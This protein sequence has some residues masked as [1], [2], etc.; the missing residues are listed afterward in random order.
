MK[1]AY[2]TSIS[3]GYMFALN[4]NMNANMYYGTNADFVIIQSQMEPEY[5]KAIENAFPFKIK[6]INRDDYS[7]C[8]HNCKYAVASTLKDD[9]DAICLIDS[10]LFICCDTTPYFY[11]ASQENVLI[12]AGHVW[13]GGDANALPFD[14]PESLIDRGQAQL[15]DFPIFINP[16]FGYKLF[17]KWFDHTLEGRGDSEANHPLV[18]FN[19]AIV[20]TLKKEELVVLPGDQWV[21]DQ[22]YWDY[23]YWQEIGEDGK[24][25]M[26]S[27][28][29]GAKTP[30]Y[31]IH[32]KWWKV[33]RASGEWLAH[34]WVVTEN[35][36]FYMNRLTAGQNN[37]NNIKNMMSWF[38]D[39]TPDSKRTDFYQGTHD[40]K[41]YLETGEV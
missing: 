17:K 19:R 26:F 7:H 23:N 37:F 10:D 6:W 22:N 3:P 2:V 18:A 14:K 24:Q 15:A 9:Y 35:N 39:M 32:N 4:A 1:F 11:R 27:S 31:A 5:M 13:S 41:K 16:K 8:F 38:N 29:R 20:N 25:H 33:G 34:R 28:L 40:W 36:E 21:C 30:I 12:T